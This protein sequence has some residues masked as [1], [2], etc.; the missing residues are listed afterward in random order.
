LP[1]TTGF[2]GFY[3]LLP[4]VTGFEPLTG[5]FSAFEFRPAVT[6]F[7]DERIRPALLP[8]FDRL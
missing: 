4:T 5:F 8:G 6:G 2:T 7:A 1:T 3:R